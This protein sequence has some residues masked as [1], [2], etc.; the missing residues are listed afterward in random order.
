MC[1]LLEISYFGEALVTGAFAV[2]Q[3]SRSAKVSSGTFKFAFDDVSVVAVRLAGML[4]KGLMVDVH[5]S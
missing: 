3:V 5:I 4:K 1:K 2:I